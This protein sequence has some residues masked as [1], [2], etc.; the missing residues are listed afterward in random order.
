MFNNIYYMQTL[1]TPSCFSLISLLADAK[2]A[3][4]TLVAV[5]V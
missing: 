2:S 3:R 5:A 4:K 1:L